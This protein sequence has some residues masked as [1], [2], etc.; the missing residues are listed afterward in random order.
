[1]TEAELVLMT[2]TAEEIDDASRW[3]ALMGD[4]WK[5]QTKLAG[6][7]NR[8]GLMTDGPWHLM[9][10]MRLALLREQAAR[11][12]A[13][14]WFA[15]MPTKD[16]VAGKVLDL[17][18]RRLELNVAQRFAPRLSRAGILEAE[19]I[20]C[21]ERKPLTTGFWPRPDGVWA[22]FCHACRGPDPTLLGED[23]D[24]PTHNP[25]AYL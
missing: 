5:T 17:Y 3:I 12:G 6:G 16:H 15:G 2:L 8:V 14:E 19:C 22:Q 4:A 7:R 25:E 13:S 18:A 21:G 9:T 24:A 1:M 11:G 23:T 10:A 20:G